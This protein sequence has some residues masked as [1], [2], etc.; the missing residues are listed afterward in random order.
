MNYLHDFLFPLR[1]ASFSFQNSLFFGR[2]LKRKTIFSL[3]Q[4]FPMLVWQQMESVF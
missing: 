4:T 2:L 3:T 1:T